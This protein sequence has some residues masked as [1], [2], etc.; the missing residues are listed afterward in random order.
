MASRA[1]N[2]IAPLRS[3]VAQRRARRRTRPKP[4]F[5][6]YAWVP[7]GGAGPITINMA[8]ASGAHGAKIGHTRKRVE[9]IFASFEKRVGPLKI[10]PLLF[11]DRMVSNDAASYALV[12]AEAAAGGAE[13]Q[14]LQGHRSER[15][16]FTKVSGPPLVA[17]STPGRR[18]ESTALA[19]EIHPLKIQ[20]SPL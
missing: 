19:C 10:G 8:K 17:A 14:P 7:P 4:Q 12:K 18:A 9:Q 16:L 13:G 6:G 11:I 1:D 20:K 2:N 3:R 15:P 5:G